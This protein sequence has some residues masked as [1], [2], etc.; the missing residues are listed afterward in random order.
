MKTFDGGTSGGQF[1]ADYNVVE[2]EVLQLGAEIQPIVAE[3]AREGADLTLTSDSGAS[4]VIHDYF[5]SFPG[6]DLITAGGARLSYDVVSKLAGPGPLAQSSSAQSDGGGPIG[7]VTELSGTVTAKHLDGTSDVLVEGASV[8]QGDVL[9]TAAGSSF[10]IEFAD[11]T[12]FSMGENGRAVLD[13]MIYNPSGGN[14]T[15]GVSLL[16]GVFS[17]VSGQIA[18]DDPENVSVKTPVG[19]IG[20]R[21]TSW[22]GEVKAFGEESIF[23]LF[24]GAIVVINEG[25]AQELTIANQSVVVTSFS[26]PPSAP[27]I[28]TGEQ[29]FNIYG[30]TLK[31]INPEWFDDEDNFDPD[32]IAPEAGGRRASNHGGGAGFEEVAAQLAAAGLNIGE[33]L[34]AGDLL[35]ATQ[36]SLDNIENI[37]ELVGAGPQTKLSVNAIIDPE[38]GSLDSFEVVIS[39]DQPAGQPV[40]ITYELRPGSATGED[41][42]LPG[43]V[44][45]IDGG[46]GTVIIA[47]GETSASFSVSVI[48][49]DVI[50]GLEFFI[51][52]LTGAENADINVAFNKAV[53]VIEDDDIG[54]VNLGDVKVGGVTVSGDTISVDED[55]GVISIELVLDKAVAPNVELNID[56]SVTG[57]ATAGSDYTTDAVQTATF[58]GGETG[59]AAGESIFITIPIIDDGKFEP[60]ESL[61]ITLASGSGNIVI[62]EGVGPITVNILDNEQPLDFENAEPA[63]LEEIADGDVVAENSL[64]LVG[65]SGTYES[66]SFNALQ[67]DFDALNLTSGGVPVVLSIT[68][69]GAL[70][71]SA[72][73]VALFTATLKDD[74]TY[75]MSLDGPIDHVGPGGALLSEIGFDL[76]FTATDENGSEATGVIPVVIGDGSPFLGVATDSTIDEDDLVDGSDQSPES[77][78][79][80]GTVEVDFGSDEAGSVTLDISG[81]PVLTSRG[82]TVEYDITTLADGVTQ[83]VTAT[84]TP[85]EGA[86]RTVFTLDF[87]PNGAGDNY[88]Y[89]VILSDVIDHTGTGEDGKALNFGYDV[90]DGDG[91]TD[92]GSFTVS[93]IDDAPIASPDSFD[94]PVP[95]MPA[96]NLVFVVDVSGSMGFPLIGGT[97][98]RIDAVKQALTSVLD[99]YATMSRAVNITVIAFASASSVVFSG[100]S[101]ADAQTFINDDGNLVPGGGTNYAAAIADNL[102]GA[103]GVLNGHLGD[104]SLADFN[105]TLYFTSDGVPNTDA[106]V[107]DDGIWQEFVDANGV[108]VVAVGIGTGTDTDELA[109]V[110]NFG[111]VPVTVVDPS[112]L[113]TVLVDNIP[114]VE[115]DNVVTSGSIDLLGADGGTL[116]SLLHNGISLDIPQNGDALELTTNLGGMISIDMAGNYVYTASQSAVLGDIESFEYFLTDGDGDVSSASLSF[117]FTDGSAGAV[118]AVAAFAAPANAGL[119]GLFEG[120]DAAELLVG[121]DGDDVLQGNG[122]SDTLTGGE[123]A[124]SFVF[125]ENDAGLVHITDFDVE[126]DSID[127]DRIFDDLGLSLAEQA[128]ALDITEIDGKAALTIS[129]AEPLTI[130]FDN[131]VNPNQQAID[132]IANNLR[133]DES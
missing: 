23:T 19:T 55:A 37:E 95:E 44:D 6:P 59:L 24:T 110:E 78:T 41:T 103:Q 50:E 3:Y 93:I 84:A 111:D 62:D 15:F 71:G 33:L 13:E 133:G 9:E 125:T 96:Y 16:Q 11:E 131:Y 34:G 20:I 70:V 89:S 2:G 121:T 69:S 81:L 106:G 17:L 53:I 115:A 109:K 21:G 36:F 108:E 1:I 4:I 12:Q 72:G 64:G 80:T 77:L 35:G 52:E 57:S 122:G 29:L 85:D 31:L 32:K 105:H 87:A 130:F 124:D 42:G 83:R 99:E 92:T 100:S 56:Y 128:N 10:S 28:L 73:G 102:D 22:S 38:S 94:L 39:L 123:G 63:L 97:G 90:V 47:P 75:D 132:D 14:G 67:P 76:A 51:V 43:D 27:F 74:G 61:V 26:S 113:E 107:P 65:G 104:L 18:K 117:T 127:L 45:F 86:P 120:T 68:T 58:S 66:I 101:I 8:Y 79:A 40:T 82:D 129:G 48:D 46:T 5:A 116:T 7:D 118:Q 91:S 126:N 98:T 60:T 30:P 54:T 114:V 88:G 112:D 49:D 25:G 119:S